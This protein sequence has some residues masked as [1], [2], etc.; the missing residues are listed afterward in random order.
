MVGRERPFL[1][2]TTYQSVFIS[3]D[4]RTCGYCHVV[5][6]LSM[7]LVKRQQ[8]RVVLNC[9]LLQN[10]DVLTSGSV[11]STAAEKK[12]LAAVSLEWNLKR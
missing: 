9:C 8:D 3:K 7:R 11:S 10:D 2:P 1:R 5:F 12:Q 6:C 4:F